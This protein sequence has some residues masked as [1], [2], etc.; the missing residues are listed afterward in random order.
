MASSLKHRNNALA[1]QREW[2]IEGISKER[3]KVG[4][5]AEARRDD[6]KACARDIQRSDKRLSESQK[7]KQSEGAA[8][9]LCLFSVS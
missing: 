5:I 7:E 9:P 6:G 2:A 8:H 4:I 1:K 3:E